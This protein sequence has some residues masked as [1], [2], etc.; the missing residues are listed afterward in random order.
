MSE[1][2]K[3]KTKRNYYKGADR[4]DRG[5]NIFSFAI[6]AIIMLLIF[7]LF[8]MDRS[9]FQKTMKEIS[10]KKEEI[11]IVEEEV[12]IQQEVKETVEEVIIQNKETE[13]ETIVSY[14]EADVD[15]LARLMYAEE[16][17]LL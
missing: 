4:F 2:I 10:L 15:L 3:V 11:P 16:G 5:D 12:S 14:T 1:K 6:G 13:E 17:V 9:S 7:L 8:M